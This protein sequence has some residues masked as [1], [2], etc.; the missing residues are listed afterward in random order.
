MFPRFVNTAR[1]G[2]W[3]IVPSAS[4]FLWRIVLPR[5]IRTPLGTMMLGHDSPNMRETFRSTAQIPVEDDRLNGQWRYF[6]H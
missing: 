5:K 4:L 2:H 3:Q 6:A 1:V